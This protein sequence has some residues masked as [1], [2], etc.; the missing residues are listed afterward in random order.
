MR[1]RERVRWEKRR[2]KEEERGIK[3]AP[4]NHQRKKGGRGVKKKAGKEREST[5]RS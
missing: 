4:N 3:S 1:Q 5:G 2:E